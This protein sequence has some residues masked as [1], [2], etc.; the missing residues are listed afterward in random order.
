MDKTQLVK[1]VEDLQH[2]LKHEK[3]KVNELQSIALKHQ[4]VKVEKVLL[5]I[6]LYCKDE[7]KPSSHAYSFNLGLS[8]VIMCMYVHTHLSYPMQ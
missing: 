4:E 3:R 8:Y 7:R 6:L 5:I 1:Q 2:A